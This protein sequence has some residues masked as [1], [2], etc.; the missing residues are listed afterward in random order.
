MDSMKV[1]D[2]QY[3]KNQYQDSSNVDARLRLHQRFSV[4]KYG[5]HCWVFDQL[6][7]PARCRILELGCGP[8]TLWLNNLDRIPEG[9]EIT[10]SDFSVGMLEC[11][12]QNLETQRPFQYKV[13]DAQSIPLESRYFDA[14]IA[15]HVLPHVPDKMKAFSE[16]CRVLIPEGCFYASTTGE[17]N[18]SEIK[19]L[20]CEFDE[21]LVSWARVSDSFTLE[22][23]MAQLAA[24][25]TEIKLYRYEDAL[26]VTEIAPLA[27]Y[28]LSGWSRQILEKRLDQFNEF[29]ASELEAHAGVFHITK[30]A[31]LF[32]SS[33]S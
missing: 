7:L 4:N 10:L 16:I 21:K 17:Q 12:R 2:P 14:V 29:V 24:W 9:W 22:N 26:D 3:L 20:V 5:W 19:D 6:K 25:F 13:I 30:D 11:A 1:N 33:R 18:L 15:N 28:I 27:D 32:V 31:G 23:G 8:G